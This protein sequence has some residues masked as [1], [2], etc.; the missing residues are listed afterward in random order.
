MIAGIAAGTG[1]S[2]EVAACILDD[3]LAL[4]FTMDDFVLRGGDED[5]VAAIT[6]AA[7]GCVEG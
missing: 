7:V 2:P 3:T 5:V 4:G 6:S 1:Q